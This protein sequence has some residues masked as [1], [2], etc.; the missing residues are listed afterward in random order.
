V[1][2]KEELKPAVRRKP[3]SER[4]AAAQRGDIDALELLIVKVTSGLGFRV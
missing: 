3:L 1:P 2:W 4:F